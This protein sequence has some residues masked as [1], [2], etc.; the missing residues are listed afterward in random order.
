MEGTLTRGKAT[1]GSA[2]GASMLL[3]E[4]TS[5]RR[6]LDETKPADGVRL[7]GEGSRSILPSQTRFPAQGSIESAE[8]S[9]KRNYQNGAIRSVHLSTLVECKGYD[10]SEN[11]LACLAESYHFHLPVADVS[12]RLL[13]FQF[14]SYS[15]LEDYFCDLNSDSDSA[16]DAEGTVW[17]CDH[18][19]YI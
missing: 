15:Q 14:H 12:K 3:V 17:Q 8:S 9:V 16:A 7:L 10:S 1:E 6:L 19:H 2:K 11:S 5:S 13:R 18:R 4:G